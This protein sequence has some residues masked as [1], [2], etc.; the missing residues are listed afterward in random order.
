LLDLTNAIPLAVISA[1][2]LGSTHCVGMC[3]GLA[4]SRS[5]TP[6]DQ[7]LYH[8]GRLFG[9]LTL[10]LVAG[11]IGEV[12][13]SERVAVG[14]SWTAS[15]LMG[16][17]FIG[18]GMQV[19][20]G[21]TP[22]FSWV[23]KRW[24][25]KAYGKGGS[26]GTGLLSAGLPCGWLQTFVLAAVATQSTVRGGVLLLCFWVGTVPALAILPSIARTAFGQ[27]LREL[28]RLTAMLLI[29]A[30]LGSFAVRV[31][32]APFRVVQTSEASPAQK[33]AP[34]EHHCH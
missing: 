25:S 29:L 14:L 11:R 30:G 16:A 28:P 32:H 9:Y 20:S 34:M 22:H 31:Y 15:I 13:F 6:L 8:F 17:V 33:A 27:R 7:A 5:R 18:L 10:G 26:F 4:L 1:S 21:K 12:L 3:G 23:P 24:L 2:L 19:W